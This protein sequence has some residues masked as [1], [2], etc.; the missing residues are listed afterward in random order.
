MHSAALRVR[1]EQA[2]ALREVSFEGFEAKLTCILSQFYPDECAALGAVGVRDFIRSSVRRAEFLGATRERDQGKYVTME[3]ALG[4]EL[5]GELV[6]VERERRRAHGAS[7]HASVLI[8]AVCR[9][10]VARLSGDDA[11][12]LDDDAVLLDEES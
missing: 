7:E 10:G 1:V 12:P 3:L 5:M 2:Q 4:P 6:T 9:A 8:G 11:L